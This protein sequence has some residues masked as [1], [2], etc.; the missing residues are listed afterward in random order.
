MDPNKPILLK[1][2]ALDYPAQTQ[3]EPVETSTCLT[4][5]ANRMI[6]RGTTVFPYNC[7]VF[8]PA[9]SPRDGLTG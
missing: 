2:L 1:Q 4:T 5:Q 8:G 9:D 7:C 3:A 6:A